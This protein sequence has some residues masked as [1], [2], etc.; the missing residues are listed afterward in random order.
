MSK[1]RPAASNDNRPP[2]TI[3]PE[4][5][6]YITAEQAAQRG[7]SAASLRRVATWNREPNGNFNAT[8]RRRQMMQAEA[9]DRVARSLEISARR[10]A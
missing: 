9:L 5:P 7:I 1:Y 10:A 6:H 2:L 8:A 3:H 4:K